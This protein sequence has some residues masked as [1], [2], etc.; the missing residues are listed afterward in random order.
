ME[1]DHIL[2]AHD[3]HPYGYCYKGKEAVQ[4]ALDA[5]IEPLYKVRDMIKAN[6][7]L[8]DEE[9]CALYNNEKTPTLGEHVV[10]QVRKTLL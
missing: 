8:S 1:I 5:C 2:T 6:P 9:I 4:K 3:Y 7:T 10:T